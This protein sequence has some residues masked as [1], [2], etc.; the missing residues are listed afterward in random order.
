MS[1][2]VAELQQRIRE[3][4]DLGQQYQVHLDELDEE[5]RLELFAS[6]MEFFKLSTELN[7]YVQ[8]IARAQNFNGVSSSAASKTAGVQFEARASELVWHMLEA[9]GTPFAKFSVRGV[10]FSWI[11]KQDSSISNRLVIRDLKA[12]NS[13]PEQIFAE[14]IAKHEHTE[15]HE[16]AKVDVFAA[17][18][19]NSLAPVGGISIVEQFELHLHPVRLQLEH[20]V[21]RNIL[22]YI[23]SQRK[24]AEDEVPGVPHKPARLTLAAPLGANAM[25][26]SSDSLALSARGGMN[27]QLYPNRPRSFLDSASAPARSAGGQTPPSESST[28]LRKVASADVLRPQV[29]EEGLDADEMRRRASLNRT[30]ILVDF[31]PTVLYLTYRVSCLRRAR[32]PSS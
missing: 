17:V 18:L 13:S 9:S 15:E 28:R 21:G 11:S 12:L 24:T 4:V 14:I 2:K 26:K 29:P 31:S 25:N 27:G 6:R 22:N 20:R 7:V 1:A 30:F 16:L 5:G 10:E 32:L 3:L 19:W 8:A 23:F